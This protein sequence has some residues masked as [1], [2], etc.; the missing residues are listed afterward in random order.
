MGGRPHWLVAVTQDL[1][2]DMHLVK[3]ID[4]QDA[5]SPAR[6]VTIPSS[7]AC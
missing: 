4:V 2:G 5:S 6:F 3:I 7:L 1:M